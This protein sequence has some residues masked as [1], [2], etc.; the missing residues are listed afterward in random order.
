MLRAAIA[1]LVLT[2]SGV[3]MDGI[4]ASGPASAQWGWFDDDPYPFRRPAYKR[5]SGDGFWGDQPRVRR[6]VVP[7]GASR[8]T[9]SGG[10]RPPIGR[11]APDRIAFPSAYPV[12]SIVIDHRGRQLLLIES[13]AE[14]L[15][16]PIS[17]GREGFGWSGTQR[18]SKIVDWPDWYPPAD[19]RERDPKLPVHMTGGL[20]NPLGAKALYLGNTLYRIHGTNDPRSIGRAS[21]SGC[22]RMLNGHVVDLASRVGAGTPVAVVRSLPPR[23]ARIV[24]EQVAGSYAPA[25]MAAAPPG[26]RPDTVPEDDAFEDRP[27]GEEPLEDELAGEGAG[28]PERRY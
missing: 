23:L 4:L 24:A 25:P 5:P 17:V 15:R 27:Q 6:P 18:I 1:G 13:P 14:A 7:R 3:L 9:W 8:S 28:A 22:F 10:P 2:A 19:M 12:S 20:K 26:R 16:Y 11:I 21:S